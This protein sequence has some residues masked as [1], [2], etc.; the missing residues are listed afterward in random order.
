MTNTG[1]VTRWLDGLRDGDHL[2]A[3]KCWEKY[4][5]RLVNLARAK[6]AG[7]PRTFQDP[8]DVALSALKSFCL[9]AKRGKFPKLDDRH[10][11]WHVLVMLTARKTIDALRRNRPNIVTIPRP[12]TGD[13]SGGLTIDDIVGDE[14]SPAFAAQVAEQR[15]Q[16]LDELPDNEIR[17]IVEL[18]LQNFTNPEIA[19]IVKRSL[20]TVERKLA[21]VRKTWKELNPHC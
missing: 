5:A 6:L 11:L 13:S 8:E 2:A 15:Q 3:Q 18:K 12:A 20:A 4:F 9:A 10:D 7:K 16:L 1:T 17:R 19:K 14:P 21:I